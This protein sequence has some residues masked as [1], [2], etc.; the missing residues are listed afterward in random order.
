MHWHGQYYK[1]AFFII[2]EF[3][4]WITVILLTFLCAL[5]VDGLK[6]DVPYFEP[7]ENNVS[8][9][10]G[11]TATLMCSIIGLQTRIVVWRRMSEPSPLTIGDFVYSQDSRISIRRVVKQNEWNLVIKDVRPDDAGVY[12]CAVSSREKYKR[13]VLLRITGT[14]RNLSRT[15]YT[16][17]NDILL[18]KPRVNV[19]GNDF[20]SKGQTILLTCNATGED[21]APDRVDWFIN[22]LKV[23]KKN[24]PRVRVYNEV[25]IYRRTLL[26]KLEIRRSLMSDTG[27]YICRGPDEKTSKITI[28]IL[29]EEK[30]IIDKRGDFLPSSE[31]GFVNDSSV[32]CY[33]FQWTANC[34]VI[35]VSATWFT[36]IWFIT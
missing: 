14:Y 3:H 30:S 18:S 7:R 28:H 12:E 24:M 33:L 2:E 26:S 4:V 23:D 6:S 19:S 9:H 17:E 13:L 8:F 27:V 15:S 16:Y 11:S 1:I 32:P 20:V 36:H 21:H 35:C 29:D 31:H 5:H 25:D 10:T 22:G 34:L